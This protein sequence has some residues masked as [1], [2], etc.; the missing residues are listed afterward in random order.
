MSRFDEAKRG[1]SMGRMFRNKLGGG[2]L[3]M[4]ALGAALAASA[5]AQDAVSGSATPPAAPASAP[6]APSPDATKVPAESAG[7]AAE[8]GAHAGDPPQWQFFDQYCSKCHNSTDWAGGV[9]FDTMTPDSFSDDAK[10][11]EEAVRKLRG[12][13]MPPPDKP[14]PDQHTIDSQIAWLETKLDANA[15]AHPDPG[16]VVMHRL[17]R[18]EYAREIENLL[19]L[20][21]D[22][23]AL[24]PKDTKADGFDNVANVLRVSPSFLDQYIVAAHDVSSMAIGDPA[25]RPTSVVYRTPLGMNQAVHNEGL[26]L[27]TRGGLLVEHLFPADGDYTFNVNQSAGFGGGYIAGL[28]SRQK[29][30]MFIDGKQVFET[31]IGGPED[32]KSL[33]QKQAPAAKEIKDRFANIKVP[34]T[35]G[36]HK[37]GIAFVARSFA[38]TDDTLEP[39]GDGLPRVPGVMGVE[40]VGPN[41][42]T[43][44]ADTP[45]RR[46]IFVCYPKNEAEELPCAKQIVSTLA[47]K[48][49][50]RPITDADMAAP[51]RFYATGREKNGFDGGIQEAVMAILASPKFLY[52]VEAP[53]KDATPGKIYPISDIELASRLSFF[54]WSQ[55]PDEELLNVATAGKL[56]QPGV[57]EKEVQRMLADPRSKSLTTSFADQWLT[58]DEM[59]RIEPDPALFPE[60]DNSLRLAFRKEIEMFVDSVFSEDQNVVNLLTANYTFV[61]E[62][63]ALHYGIPNIRGE[64]FRRVTLTDS[65][66]FGLLGKGSFLMG[67]SY[68]N[69]TSPVRRGAWILETITGTP[70]HAPPPGVE[71][72]KENMDGKKAQTVRERMVAHRTN[73]TCN[74]CHGIIDPIG[75]SLENFDALGAWRDKDRETGTVID[76]T[77]KLHGE[78][79]SGPDQLRA[80]ILRKPDQFVQTI[81]EKLMTYALGRGVE[82]T[83]MPTV[84]AI[85]R[86]AAQH[87]YRFSSIVTGIVTSP[88]F[89]M[90]K[91]PAA[92]GVDTKTAQASLH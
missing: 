9:A 53:P 32:L 60:F 39:L 85:V 78:T 66:R 54:L 3:V 31:E 15:Q 23:A 22:A 8:A 41:K 19:D 11:W 4:L 29:L 7:E 82:Y 74:A 69:R 26:P 34:V 61:N 73:P 46:K 63:L 56:R 48:A 33:D 92:T 10:V 77:D 81:T 44:L 50:R 24:L 52:R 58:V 84:R 71:A 13:L 17:N 25:A 79:V 65:H 12:R 87:D 14:Q 68:A 76:S 37:I 90:Q 75:F 36:P 91:V 30:V 86:D 43:G 1:D 59:D 88:P 47:R 38:E 35:A 83:D 51:M 72:L 28:D 42:A 67:M 27:G 80:Y 16:S 89:Q 20:K 6:P 21:I 64:R 62:R 2:S 40:I 45:S 49:Y 55:G 70:P 57:L 5:M 18:T